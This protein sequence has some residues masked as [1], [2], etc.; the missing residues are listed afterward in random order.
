MSD[1]SNVSADIVIVELSNQIASLSKESAILKAVVH[2]LRQ[3]LFIQ[4][5]ELAS[6]KKKD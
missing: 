5:Q 2:K 3:Q 6:L 1:L 4:E